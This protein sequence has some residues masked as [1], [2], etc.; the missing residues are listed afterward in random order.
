[1]KL[2]KKVIKKFIPSHVIAQLRNFYIL[3]VE[4]GQYRT[5]KNWECVD[6]NGEPLPW[7]TYPAIEYLTTLDFSKSYV[8][9]FG[10]GY[11]TAWWAKRAKFVMTVE[12]NY[13]WYKKIKDKLSN[14]N[15]VKLFLCE[16]KEDYVNSI[17]RTKTV[18][19]VVVIDGAWRGE[20]AKMLDEAVLNI[21][22]GFMIILDN[23]DWYPKTTRYIRDKWDLIR[24]D[25]HGFSP[26]NS[27]TLT[28]TI[29]FSRNFKPYYL[30]KLIYSV[31][32]IQQIAQDDFS[33]M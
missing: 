13:D 29:F 33:D 15:N 30:D 24:V 22:D 21:R 14:H 23:S 1:M 26:I 8:F 28:T 10:G 19:D 27:Y 2:T 12:S 31:A 32:P 20:C 9:E 16:N 3:A 18:F 6:K 25:F 7:Y 17:L 5:I 11:S 4:Y